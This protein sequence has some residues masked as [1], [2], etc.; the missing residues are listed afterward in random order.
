MYITPH[1][2]K[3]NKSIIMNCR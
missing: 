3:I 1:T 2:A